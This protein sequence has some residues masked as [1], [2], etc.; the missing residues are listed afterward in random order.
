[1][2]IR[3]VVKLTKRAKHYAM[4]F[5]AGVCRTNASGVVWKWMWPT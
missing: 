4:T 1:M 2:K 3:C 5:N